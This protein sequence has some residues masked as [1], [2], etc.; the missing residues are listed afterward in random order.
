MK[1]DKGLK[2]ALVILLIVLVSIISFAGL[3]VQDKKS[4]VNV[5]KDYQLG[6]DLKGS[7]VVTTNVGTG[8]KT[9]YY[10]KDGNEVKSEDKEGSKKEVPINSEESLIVD[11]YKKTKNIVEKRLSDYG[12]S[13]YLIRLDEKTGKMTVQIPEDDDTDLAVQYIYTKGKFTIVGENNEVL[14][15]ETNVKKATA[16]YG[17]TTSGTTVYLN[18]EFNKDSVEKL[19]KISNTYVKSTDESGKDTTKKFTMKIDDNTITS[20]SFGE[21]IKN[22]ILQISVGSATTNV[23][24][25]NSYL[26]EA[27]NLAILIN[28]G[29]LPLEYDLAQNRFISSDITTDNLTM[30]GIVILVTIVIGAIVLGILYKK[31][32]ILAG[33]ANIGY[34][35]VL[36]IIVRYTNVILTIEGIFG[37]LISIVLNYIFTIRLLKTMKTEEDTK[38]AYNNTAKSMVFIL[39]PALVIAI[40][41]CFA[42]WMPIYS[43]GAL[44]FWGLLTIFIYNTVI[45]RTLMVIST[46]K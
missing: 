2:I 20:T 24:E 19:R 16:T 7:R 9:I 42:G 44:M 40:A 31:N 28:D 45:T 22:G 6:M 25:I 14:L 27:R 12:I 39:I 17:T 35:A 36:L 10:D 11:N 38:K 30:A 43:F 29:S 41:L 4:M 1:V 8:N 23:S 34:L 46:K 3:Y 33:I 18:I 26:A 5:L 32:G 21:E 37:I 13:E 15:D